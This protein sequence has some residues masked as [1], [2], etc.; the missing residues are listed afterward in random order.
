MV[1][2]VIAFG[3]PSKQRVTAKVKAAIDAIIFEALPVAQASEKAGIS[4]HGLYKAMRKPPVMAYYRAQLDLL[5]T[6]AG[7]AGVAKVVQM[8]HGAGSEHVQL[9]AAQWAAGLEGYA[10]VVRSENLHLHAHT[11]PGITI[12]REAYQ[13]HDVAALPAGHLIEQRARPAVN[14]IGVSV[15]HP[16]QIRKAGE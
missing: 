15:P 6:S 1:E 5:R 10:P 16:S 4:G 2:R 8:M 14:R 11:T 9:A 3:K 13:P 12:V 7:P